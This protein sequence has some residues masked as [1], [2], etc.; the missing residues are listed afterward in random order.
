MRF[1]FH[2]RDGSGQQDRLGQEFADMATA[3]AEVELMAIAALT[4]RPEAVWRG[5]GWSIDVMD[6]DGMLVF[7]L[8]LFSSLSPRVQRLL[9]QS[10]PL[11]VHP[12]R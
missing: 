6:A 11:T 7:A 12:R 8:H 10:R 9:Q 4:N 5:G 3:R 1:F 2:V